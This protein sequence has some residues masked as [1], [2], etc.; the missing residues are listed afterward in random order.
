MYENG[1][2]IHSNL[3]VIIDK[4]K[5]NGIDDGDI[6]LPDNSTGKRW[7]S[8]TK[9]AEGIT[10]VDVADNSKRISN[11]E[12]R[13]TKDNWTNYLTEEEKAT[14]EDLK[15][16]CEAR[17]NKAQKTNQFLEMAKG[18]TKEEIMAMLAMAGEG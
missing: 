17:M 4:R 16:R 12:P 5:G 18:F 3:K 14:F 15:S 9:F 10:E 11:G 7:L 8:T 6:R 13:A 2:L 1:E